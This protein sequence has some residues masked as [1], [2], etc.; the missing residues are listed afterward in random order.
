MIFLI[1]YDRERGTLVQLLKYS[2]DKR[3]DAT[4]AR[5]NLEL[6]QMKSDLAHEIVILEAASEEHLR[7]THRRYFEPIGTL[8][9]PDA[10]IFMPRA[11]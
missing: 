5:L 7:R 2:N 6:L 1:E 8:A 9:D 11:A 10:S 4:L 3:A